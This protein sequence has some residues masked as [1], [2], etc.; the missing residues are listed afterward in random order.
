MLVGP[1]GPVGKAKGTGKYE[2]DF[3]FLAWLKALLGGK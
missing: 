3:G 1:S 2:I